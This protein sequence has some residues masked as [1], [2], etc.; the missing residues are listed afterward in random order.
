M[1]EDC[2]VRTVMQNRAGDEAT[3]GVLTD[4]GRRARDGGLRKRRDWRLMEE[5]DCVL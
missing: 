1:I 4:W 3:S 5:C 2:V